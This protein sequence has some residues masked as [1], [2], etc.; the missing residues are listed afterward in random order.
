MR[1]LFPGYYQPSPD[2]FKNLWTRGTF[3]LDANVLLNLYTYPESVREVFLSVVE[4]LEGRIWIPYQVALEFHRNRL[5]RIRQSN[6]RIEKLLQL[7]QKNEDELYRELQEVE[8]EKRRIGIDDLPVRLEALKTAHSAIR[9]AVT[10]AIEKLP[11]ISLEDPIGEKLAELLKGKI[12]PAPKNQEEMDAL[13][14]DADAR[15]RD[16]IP[17]GFADSDKGPE[18][19][20]DR[21]ISYPRRFGDLVMWKQTLANAKTQKLTEVVL[22]TGDRKPDWWWREDHRTLGPLPE[23]VDEM[24]FTAEVTSFWMYMPDQFLSYAETYLQAREVTPEAIE[25]VKQ[26]S[27]Q[28]I[29]NPSRFADILGLLSA[30]G[31][32]GA[33]GATRSDIAAWL[34][35][36]ALETGKTSP[37]E[38][39]VGSTSFRSGEKTSV[40]LVGRWL[41]S[42]YPGS[43]LLRRRTFPDLVVARDDDLHGYDVKRLANFRQFLF[44]P[45]VVASLLRGYLEV[46]ESRLASFSLVLIISD[47]ETYEY[48]GDVD[49]QHTNQ[50]SLRMNKLLEKYP[51]RSIILGSTLTG[52]FEPLIVANGRL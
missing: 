1:E 2:E 24:R 39:V 26:P 43:T 32:T 38:D 33:T 42:N 27:E 13:L 10:L 6:Q 18:F 29:L 8:L 11:S 40:D 35:S 16:R 47:E 49:D 41:L 36:D 22:I 7:I 28:A 30:T 5:S 15:Y 46:R 50:A 48:M 4:K 52:Q 12:G 23:L 17:P 20:R 44:P 21:G 25:R 34:S 9:D 14:A 45:S 3:V 51:A 31:A 37:G 19:Q